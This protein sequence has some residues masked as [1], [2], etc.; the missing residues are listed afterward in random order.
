MCTKDITLKAACADTFYYPPEWNPSRGSL[1][2]FQQKKGFEH[3]FGKSRTKNLDKGILVI[4]FEMPFP[5][6]CLRCNNSIGQGTRYDAD[7]KGCGKYFSTTLY[8]FQMRCGHIVDPAISADGGVHCNQRFV[9]RTDPKN[10]DYELAE[11]LR[12]RVQTWDA[13]DAGTIELVDPETRRQMDGDPMLK[14]EKTIRD[15]KKEKSDKERLADLEDLQAEREDHYSLNCAL[16]RHNRTKRKEEQEKEEAER[17]AGPQNFA[18][19]LVPPHPADSAR[20]KAVRFRT[21]HDRIELSARRAA[22]RAAPLFP[23]AVKKRP[24][25]LRDAGSSSK[26]SGA[27][28]GQAPGAAAA[29]LAAKR[30]RVAAHARMASLFKDKII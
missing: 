29:E 24:R 25:A 18:L 15:A 30:R 17:R 20:A 9:I 8:E 27:A 7:K 6:Q 11:G 1:D 12:R 16:R 3:Y 5:V 19:P 21:D 28:A 26:A 2:Q 13:K 22:A 10:R 23:V 4:R 14:V